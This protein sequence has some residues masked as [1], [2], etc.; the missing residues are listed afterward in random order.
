MS[1]DLKKSGGKV[2]KDQTS[3]EE[4]LMENRNGMFTLIT[5]DD[6]T[7]EHQYMCP[8]HSYYIEEKVCDSRQDRG[9]K[10]CHCCVVKKGGS[11]DPRSYL[12]E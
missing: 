5:F 8:G 3:I 4:G 10:S 2:S 1:E 9:F 12:S 11:A 7:W 6:G